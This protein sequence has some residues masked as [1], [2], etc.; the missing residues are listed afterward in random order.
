[1]ARGRNNKKKN[2]LPWLVAGGVGLYFLSRSG[3]ARAQGPTPPLDYSPPSG[4]GGFP[5]YRGY[6]GGTWA[7]VNNNPQNILKTGISWA[8][9]VPGNTTNYEMFENMYYGWLAAIKNANANVPLTD[10]TTE[11]LL[12]RLHVGSGAYSSAA[13]QAN[14]WIMDEMQK[15]GAVVTDRIPTVQEVGRNYDYN[16]W[17]LFHRNNARLEAGNKFTPEIDASKN[18]FTAAFN[19]FMLQNVGA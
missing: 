18:A 10:R 17:W 4:G 13:K 5:D 11:G 19:D 6:P 9:E 12:R 7:I 16:W 1:M 14:R 3:S 2:L 15:G 8:G